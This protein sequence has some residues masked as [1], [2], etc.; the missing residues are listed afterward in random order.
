VW[1][2]SSIVYAQEPSQV[3]RLA[4]FYGI[5][6]EASRSPCPPWPTRPRTRF[7]F[8]ESPARDPWQMAEQE[9]RLVIG[10][11]EVFAQRVG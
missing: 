11:L 3:E 4:D 5:K 10:Q 1:T 2:R 6:A 8:R 9:L 7:A